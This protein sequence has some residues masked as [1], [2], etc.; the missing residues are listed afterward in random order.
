MDKV[1]EIDRKTCLLGLRRM[2]KTSILFKI[3]NQIRNPIPI[4]INCYG[5]PD[6][7]R[8]ASILSDSI[9]DAYVAYT[10]DGKYKSAIRKYIKESIDKIAYQLTDMELSVGHY[11]KIRI[12]LK[13]KDIDQDLLVEDAFNYTEK[14]GRSKNKKFVLILDEF[15]DIG[16][17][18]GG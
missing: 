16:S 11:F 17:R 6:K 13:Q 4:Y 8:F 15:Q 14:L 7:R 9:K 2:G 12:G 5:I 18:W 1:K 3:V 10:G